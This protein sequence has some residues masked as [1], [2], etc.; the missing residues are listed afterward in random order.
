MTVEEQEAGL[1]L[2]AN[3][4]AEELDRI[5]RPELATIFRA[6][7]RRDA[8]PVRDAVRLFPPTMLDGLREMVELERE[9]RREAGEE[10]SV[11]ILDWLVDL[12]AEAQERGT[13]VDLEPDEAGKIH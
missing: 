12:V 8:E 4:V 10:R 2:W 7:A 13:T 1:T 5:E 11:E 9:E 3:E 6:L